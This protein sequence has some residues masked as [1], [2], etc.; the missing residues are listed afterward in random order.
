VTQKPPVKCQITKADVCSCF[1]QVNVRKS[2]GPDHTGGRLLRNCAEQLSKIY[3]FIFN[4]SLQL[5]KVPCL[6]KDSI[7]M[8]IAKKISFS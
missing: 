6:W 4:K 3:S 2:P 1:G 5:S 7:V 8:R